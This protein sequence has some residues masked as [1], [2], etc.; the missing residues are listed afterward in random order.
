MVRLGLVDAPPKPPFILGM[1]CSGDV[2]AVGEGVEGLQVGDKVVALSE[3]RAWAELVAVPA[4]FVYKLPEGMS[5]QDAAAI[6]LSY[7]VA[8]L[9]LFELGGLT[10][11][12]KVLLHSAGG[13]VVSSHT[14][15]TGM[16]ALWG[17]TQVTNPS[18]L[19]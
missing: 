4:K 14:I 15:N 9:L 11:G 1:E 7:T 13:G 10:P 19:P 8:H 5:Y 18:P 12:K 17:K 6:T 3:Y 16:P 2:E